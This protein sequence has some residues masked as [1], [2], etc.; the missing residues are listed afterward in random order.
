MKPLQLEF[1]AFGPYAGH[2][3]VDFEDLSSKGLFLICGETG[4]GK[5]MLLDAMTFAL[6]GKSSGN[7]RND[8]QSMRCTNAD[9][10]TTTFVKFTFEAGGRIYIFERR[11]ERKRKNLSASYNL[12]EKVDDE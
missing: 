5:T 9:F 10:D 6:Y 2:E 8:F 1:Q 12:M 3:F 4:S 11:L 7:L